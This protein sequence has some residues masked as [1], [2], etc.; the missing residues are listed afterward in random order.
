MKKIIIAL[1]IVLSLTFTLA[2][3]SMVNNIV[4]S[5]S[6]KNIAY[7]EALKL[8]DEGQYEAA[9]EVFKELGDFKDS[10]KYLA[11]FHYMMVGVTGK[12]VDGN[13]TEELQAEILL[14]SNNLLEKFSVTEDPDYS[15]SYE[16]AYNENGK[17]SK[18]IEKDGNWT[19]TTEY[20]Y[21]E[22]GN[23]VK[24][25][26]N[27]NE[28]LYI[29]EYTYDNSGNI[30]KHTYTVPD[31]NYVTTMEYTYD[32]KN[33]E[34]KRVLV[35]GSMTNEYITTYT[36]DSNGNLIKESTTDSY[37]GAFTAEFSYDSNCN[38]I[39]ISEDRLDT[40]TNYTYDEK[41]QII[42]IL[43]SDGDA[44]EYVYD[45]N[46]NITKIIYISSSGYYSATEI[47]YKLVYIPFD[48]TEEEFKLMLENTIEFEYPK[49]EFNW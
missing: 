38:L 34:I 48:M 14:N 23:L 41:G 2:S 42:K 37:G 45:G 49:A 20:E 1:L 19:S 35:D 32:E 36:Y 29:T 13:E 39:R 43:E 31:M 15:W 3:C 8:L 21:D 5:I 18:K 11:R 27:R 9:Y 10:E 25:T 7:D 46:G 26:E 6:P 4:E 47:E 17:L 16:F 33:N 30:V 12:S 28:R 40:V 44:E 22:K 24:R